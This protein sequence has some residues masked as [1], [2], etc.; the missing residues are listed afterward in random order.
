MYKDHIA[1][2][3]EKKVIVSRPTEV[4]ID[5]YREFFDGCQ[6]TLFEAYLNKGITKSKGI[7]YKPIKITAQG[8]LCHVYNPKGEEGTEVI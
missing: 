8:F 6:M 2:R 5:K 7:L 1:W 3:F 4:E